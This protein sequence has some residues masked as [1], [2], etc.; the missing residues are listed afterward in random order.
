LFFRK[1]QLPDT[2]Q[3]ADARLINFSEKLLTGTIGGASAKIL[4]ASVVKEE[5]VSLVEV[6]E[7]LDESKETMAMN[8]MLKEKSHELTKLTGQLKDANLELITKDKQK[9]EFLDTLA[10]ELKT[11]ITGIRGAAEL[12]LDD[13][14]EMPKDIKE[15]FLKNIL[16]DSDRFT[17]LIQNLLDFE[18]LD[19]ERQ[20]IQPKQRNFKTTLT[21]VVSSIGQIAAA[22]NVQIEIS[23]SDDAFAEFDEDRM[24]QVLTNLISNGIKFCSKNQGW[25]K[26]D[27]TI[28]NNQLIVR[29]QDNGAGVPEEDLPYV[30]D[31]FYQSKNQNTIKPEG[32]GLGLAISKRI[33]ER[34]NGSI[35]VVNKSNSGANFSFRF[36][37][38]QDK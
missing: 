36:P 24:I 16:Q 21:R 29:V 37:I 31:K 17:R 7:I 15:Q 30:F 26:I 3:M 22:K 28:E 32:S 6:L 5:E 13:G 23:S 11:P 38:N 34:H 18:K 19:E 25:V 2:T 10:H 14:D 8:K 9:D 1:Y 27:Y 33:V 35:S 4:I 12:L 20:A